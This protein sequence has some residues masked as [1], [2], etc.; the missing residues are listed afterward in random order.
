MTA[1]RWTDEVGT[2]ADEAGRLLE[3]LRRAGL[4][5]ATAPAQEAGASSG[6]EPS[7]DPDVPSDADA[8]GTRRPGT[9]PPGAAAGPSAGEGFS[10]DD[11]VCQWCPVCRA[12]AVLRR[13]SP[14]T[15]SGL[16]ELAGF[17]ATVLGDLAAARERDRDTPPGPEPTR[18]EQPGD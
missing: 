6:P 10:C 2:V 11:P 17:A 13:L 18:D 9:E 4:D 12:S 3:S 1:Q 7:A 5:A 14:E 8:R 15:L 16:S